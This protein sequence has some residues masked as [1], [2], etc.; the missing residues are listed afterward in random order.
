MDEEFNIVYNMDE[1]LGEYWSL[2]SGND[3]KRWFAK[4]VHLRHWFGVKILDDE[5]LENL[6]T[7]KKG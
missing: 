3:R 1:N 4:E 7:A 6:R 5:Q 2:I